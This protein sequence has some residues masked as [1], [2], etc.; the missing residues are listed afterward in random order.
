[1][2]SRNSG[3]TRKTVEEN[4]QDDLEGQ[5]QG[6]GHLVRLGGHQSR[7]EQGDRLQRECPQVT[8]KGKRKE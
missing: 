4:P 8:G 5:S 3:S 2:G 7:S 6:D 1:M